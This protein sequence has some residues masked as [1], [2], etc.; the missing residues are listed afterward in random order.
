LL[1]SVYLMISDVLLAVPSRD[2]GTRIGVG[3]LIGLFVTVIVLIANF[4]KKGKKNG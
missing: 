3:L 1:M 2:P 4:L